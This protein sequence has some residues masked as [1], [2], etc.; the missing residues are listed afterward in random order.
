MP[1]PGAIGHAW[2]YAAA[3]LGRPPPCCPSP[4]DAAATAQLPPLSFEP[5]LYHP[6]FT[7]FAHLISPSGQSLLYTR[8]L[9]ARPGRAQIGARPA[10]AAAL[11]LSAAR[12]ILI[13]VKRTTLFWA[14]LWEVGILLQERARPVHT[15]HSWTGSVRHRRQK[16]GSNC[17]KGVQ[18]KK[19]GAQLSPRPRAGAGEE[20]RGRGSRHKFRG[21]GRNM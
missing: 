1:T 2:R 12:L 8:R 19:G 5:T 18:E 14:A 21:R 3:H 6:L 13:V 7:F 10:A 11:L 17:C 20:E 15:P 4:C 16:G 9:A